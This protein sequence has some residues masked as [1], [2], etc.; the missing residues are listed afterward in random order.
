MAR[1]KSKSKKAP[2]PEQEPPPPPPPLDAKPTIRFKQDVER[3][4]KRGKDTGKL[5]VIIESLCHHRPLEPR[6]RDHALTGD[7]KGWRDCHVEPDWVLI[8][9]RDGGA[10]ILGRTGTHSDL[11][12][13]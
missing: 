4:K 3:Q 9:R 10:L 2:A 1:R 11:G 5:R 8:Y 13:E 7:W 6:Y 12:L